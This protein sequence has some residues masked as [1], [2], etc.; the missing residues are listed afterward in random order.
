MRS[1]RQPVPTDAAAANRG[2]ALFVTNCASCHGGPKW[3]KS[4]IFYR[5]NP[6]FNENPAAGG[7]PLDAGVTANGAQIVSFASS[8]LTF[9]YLED[10]GTFNATNPLEIRAD[11]QRAFG[12]LGFNVPSLIGVN[13]TAPYFHNGAAPTLDALYPLHKLGAGTIASVLTVAQ[14]QDLTAFLRTIAAAT[15]ILRSE[16]DDFRDAVAQ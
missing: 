15:D 13:S 16:A 14:R 12:A 10:V 11:G 3:T 2:R 8:G 7:V 4:T 9:K 5:D 6:A 1:L